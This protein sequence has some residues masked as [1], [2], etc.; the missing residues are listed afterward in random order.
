[1]WRGQRFSPPRQE[2]LMDGNRVA[3]VVAP[4][5]PA[6]W[7]RLVT[8]SVAAVV[9]IA[10]FVNTA[11]PYLMLDQD[12]MAR[13]ASRRWSLLMH[14][15][16]GTVALLIGP[17]QLW[18]GASRRAMSLHRWFGL[19]YVTSV[20]VGSIA[21]FNLAWQTTLGWVFGAGI[22]GLG[23]AWVATTTMAVAAIRRGLIAQHQDWMIRSY[24]VTFAFVTFRA[25]WSVLDAAHI[26]TPREQLGVA[27]WFCWA[28]PL[29][30]TELVLQGRRIFDRRHLGATAV[31]CAI[32][33]T[34]A[35]VLAQARLAGADLEGLVRDESGAVLPAAMAT[36]TNTE[37]GI[38]RSIETGTD[39]RF[40]ALALPP[41]TDRIS[42]D[43]SGFASLTRDGF[44]LLLGQSVSLDFT[45]RLASLEEGL[46]VVADTPVV[47][48]GHTAVS[49]V[50]EREHV[51]NLPTNVRNFLSFSLI[52]PGVAT[53]R[54]PQQGVTATSARRR[55]SAR[56]SG[57]ECSEVRFEKGEPSSSGP[58]S[59][60]RSTHTTSST[61][62]RTRPTSCART[63]LPSSSDTCRTPFAR[64]T[65][66]PRSITSSRLPVRS[67]FA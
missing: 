58:S 3:A 36:V 52:T 20:G 42:I 19:T 17:V 5:P 46:T 25:L 7:P 38:A 31:C 1:M 62:I 35:P 61:S 2:D 37:T 65:C 28:V 54:T 9:A 41:G 22:T 32:V 8:I 48:T 18:L 33:I 40:R 14:V 43:R 15:A 29:L 26:G 57:A 39:G 21:A 56:C 51:D 47:E 50:V 12:A 44:V 24:V 49:T 67:R 34:S 59:S 60:W 63:A 13:Y 64:Q 30:V 23:I 53:D 16:A 45:M 55:R 10:F 27:S 11:L 4:Y 66:S 6:S